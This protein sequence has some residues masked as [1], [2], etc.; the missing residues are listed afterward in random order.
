MSICHSF[1]FIK[2]R[3]NLNKSCC[4][5]LFWSFLIDWFFDFY[6]FIWL[7]V[8]NVVG[9]SYSW[10][11]ARSSESVHDNL[12]GFGA[13]AI[14]CSI[15]DSNGFTCSWA[16]SWWH[17]NQLPRLQWVMVKALHCNKALISMIKLELLRKTGEIS[18]FSIRHNSI[19]FT[20]FNNFANFTFSQF[21]D[22]S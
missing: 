16:T 17:L 15:A 20:F 3:F 7:W 2:S 1:T 9:I 5:G 6:F 19:L 14:I 8:I 13:M 12:I 18:C 21:I 22:L 4:W 11:L 10:L